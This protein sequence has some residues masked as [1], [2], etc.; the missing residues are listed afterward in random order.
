VTEIAGDRVTVQNQ[1]GNLMHVSR[2]IL[3]KMSSATHFAKEVPMNMTG[4]AELLTTVSD[5]IFTVQFRK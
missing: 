2:D 1:Y 3:E 5:T 4:L